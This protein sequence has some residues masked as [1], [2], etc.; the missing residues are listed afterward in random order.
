M[1]KLYAITRIMFLGELKG[2]RRGSCQMKRSIR[3]LD[4]RY[5]LDDK[6]WGLHGTYNMLGDKINQGYTLDYLEKYQCI[7][8]LEIMPTIYTK[9]FHIYELWNGPPNNCFSV[10]LFGHEPGKPEPSKGRRKPGC[11]AP[12]GMESRR[13]KDS[14]LKVSSFSPSG[15]NM[16][17]SYARLHVHGGWCTKTILSWKKW[18][19]KYF[20]P[21][22]YLE[23]DLLTENFIDAFATQGHSDHNN[24]RW[25]TGYVVHYS[26][27]AF[28]WDVIS[29]EERERVS[30]VK[31]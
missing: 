25:V 10:D 1:K 20:I 17:A 7:A 19:K 16:R 31:C 24:P 15:L 2:D 4:L 12:L 8:E 5:S 22:H 14:Q 21:N 13:I 27:N 3:R 28:S 11:D 9:I 6:I 23:I 29:M 26:L 30:E 18:D